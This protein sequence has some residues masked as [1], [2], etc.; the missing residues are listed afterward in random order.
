MAYIPGPRGGG[1][2]GRHD[3]FR[4]RRHA[5]PE[6]LGEGERETGRGRLWTRGAVATLALSAL[7]AATPTAAAQQPPTAELEEARRHV[8]EFTAQEAAALASLQQ[9]TERLNGLNAQAA[10]L[11]AE[12]GRVSAQ[13]AAAEGRLAD[14]EA[15]VVA[16]EQR[17]AEARAALVATEDLLVQQAVAVYVGR[18]TAFEVQSQYWSASSITVAQ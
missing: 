3:R 4:H 13:L 2:P 10:A 6:R 15:A 17:L 7:A 9:A 12:I 14:A 18:D 11:D 16:A 5:L 8:D 1:L